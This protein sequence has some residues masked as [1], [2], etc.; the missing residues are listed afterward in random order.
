MNVNLGYCLETTWSMSDCL[1]KTIFTINITCRAIYKTL[2]LAVTINL[3]FPV[4][5][6]LLFFIFLLLLYV[7]VENY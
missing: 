6:S 1:V 2:S 5:T 7:S 3:T 4:I